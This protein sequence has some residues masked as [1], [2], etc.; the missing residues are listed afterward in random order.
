MIRS[1]PGS[2]KTQLAFDIYRYCSELEEDITC[3]YVDAS[4]QKDF[5]YLTKALD[6][7]QSDEKNINEDNKLIVLVDEIQKQ[8]GKGVS[9]HKKY[10]TP[11]LISF[12]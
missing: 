9:I 6:L 1:P 8:Y 7:Y 2:G 3:I 12:C 11:V 4:K 5:D 10:S